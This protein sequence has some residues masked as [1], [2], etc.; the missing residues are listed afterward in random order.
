MALNSKDGVIQLANTQ[1]FD[2]LNDGLIIEGETLIYQLLNKYD[3][4][5]LWLNNLYSKLYLKQNQ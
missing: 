4:L 5:I 1:Y 2:A 3:E